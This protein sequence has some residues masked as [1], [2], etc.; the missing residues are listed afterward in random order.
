MPR[1]NLAARMGEAQ[2]GRPEREVGRQALGAKTVWTGPL[3]APDEL[4]VVPGHRARPQRASAGGRAYE[5]RGGP[6]IG[7][8]GDQSFRSSPGL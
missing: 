8:G 3:V 5:T 1:K 7:P 2:P 6:R 4:Y